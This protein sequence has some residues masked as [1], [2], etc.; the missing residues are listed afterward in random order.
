[1][2]HQ[3]SNVLIVLNYNDAKTTKEFIERTRGNQCVDH[4]VIVDNHSTDNSYIDLL[5]YTDEKVD[6]IQID[7]NGGYAKGNNRGAQ[8]AIKKYCPDYLLISNP[9]VYFDEETIRLLESVLMNS[10]RVGAVACMMKCISGSSRPSAWKLPSFADCIKENMI[11]TKKLLGDK[12]LYNEA[13]LNNDMVVNVDVVSGA[14]FGISRKTFLNIGGFDED[15]FLYGE[16]NLM[17]YKLKQNGYQSKLITGKEYLHEHSTSID[18]SVNSLYKKLRM[19]FK[20]RMVYANKVLHMNLAH[21]LILHLTFFIGT[22]NYLI[23]RK[24]F[25]FFCK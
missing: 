13:Y 14:F 25:D 6:V 4:I 2:I 5:Q 1:M 16:E 19:G 11:I 24:T 22:F 18:K 8:Y 15:T 10:S 23:L 20:S 9:D 7:T 12:T 3:H 21:K 17:A